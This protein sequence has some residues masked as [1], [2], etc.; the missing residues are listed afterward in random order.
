MVISAACST[1]YPPLS[2]DLIDRAE[3]YDK[4]SKISQFSKGIEVSTW[5]GMR[6]ETNLQ[7]YHN[8]IGFG[9]PFRD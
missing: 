5:M 2:G 1:M 3:K 7:R 6:A 9:S 8:Q 4:T